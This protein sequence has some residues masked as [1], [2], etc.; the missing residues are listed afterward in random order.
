MV[1][2][3]YSFL[4][5][6]G[7]CRYWAFP[8]EYDGS[9][10]SIWS[11][12]VTGKLTPGQ[13]AKLKDDLSVIQWQAWDQKHFHEPGLFDAGTATFWTP[14]A[15][16]QCSGDCGSNLREEIY[17]NTRTWIRT[18]AEQGDPVEG[19]VRVAAIIM[20]DEALPNPLQPVPEDIDL[21]EHAVSFG[22]AYN[23]CFGDGIL[24]TGDVAD[25][26]R[27][28]RREYYG[29]KYGNFDYRY[30]P[31]EAA[32]GQ[33][34]MVYVRDTTPPEGDNGLV[35]LEGISTSICPD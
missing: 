9:S 27:R 10:D 8:R 24:V 29:G 1:E 28:Y 21:R 17:T 33:K 7:Q 35:Q 22:D 31:L 4:Y 12:V 3:G 11:D 16:F 2:N 13:E 19:A 18:L 34:Y 23:I 15:M 30:L 5:L 32:D 26:L 25:T 6:D 14:M 20:P